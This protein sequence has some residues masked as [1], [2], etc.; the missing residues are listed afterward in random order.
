[1]LPGAEDTRTPLELLHIVE[2]AVE[3]GGAPAFFAL[4]VA[5]DMIP[6]LPTHPLGIMAGA[7]YGSEGL[8]KPLAIVSCGQTIAALAAF[9]IS[10][11]MMNKS[12]QEP[13]RGT[14]GSSDSAIG[15]KALGAIRKVEEMAENGGPWGCFFGTVALRL[16]SVFPFSAG[17]YALGLTRLPLLPFVLGTF[18][19]CLPLN[20]FLVSAG[21]AGRELLSEEA[22]GGGS[23]GTHQIAGITLPEWAPAVL[24]GAAVA[25]M[26]FTTANEV[27]AKHEE[28][29]NESKA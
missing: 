14:A 22:A 2:T 3:V 13:A 27:R 29:K 10:R 4:V 18:L 28:T 11:S 1:M 25:Y 23:P 8:L 24:V 19:G 16:S 17:N 26:V 5:G 21:A 6:F 12:L 7:L 15:G 20:V 9:S